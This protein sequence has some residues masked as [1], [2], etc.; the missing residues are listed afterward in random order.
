MT[1]VLLLPS[2]IRRLFREDDS[3]IEF[4]ANTHLETSPAYIYRYQTKTPGTVSYD[5]RLNSSFLVDVGKPHNLSFHPPIC[6]PRAL[7]STPWH[8]ATVSTVPTLM[9][10]PRSLLFPSSGPLQK[11]YSTRNIRLQLAS[12]DTK[13]TRTF[14]RGE[15]EF[16][17]EIPSL[18]GEDNCLALDKESVNADIRSYVAAQLSQ[19]RGFRD[20][21]LS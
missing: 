6:R 2:T 5:P 12:L 14:I 4:H 13:P 21:P 17:R 19:R 7:P 1:R 18:M 9:R 3:S 15:P 8:P 20:K 16:M 10:S 11:R